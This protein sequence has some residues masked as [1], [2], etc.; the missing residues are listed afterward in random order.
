MVELVS[1]DPGEAPDWDEA[2][3]YV[4]ALI[5]EEIEDDLVEQCGVDPD[6]DPRETWLDIVKERLLEDLRRFRADIEGDHDEIEEWEFRGARVFASVG[7]TDDESNPD[8]GHGWLCRLL[9]AS[10]LGAAG[11]ERVRRASLA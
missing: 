4:A 2:E 6:R 5:L 10:A 8:S 11:F 7:S 3:R 1:L 9:D